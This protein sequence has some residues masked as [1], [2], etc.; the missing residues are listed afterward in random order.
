[1]RHSKHCLLAGLVCA[2]VSCALPAQADNWINQSFD[3]G[4]WR[5][6]FQ[7][8]GGAYSGET[9]RGGDYYV[10]ASIEYEWPVFARCT[11]GLRFYPLFL[12]H[13]EED[14]DYG[15]GTIYGGAFGIAGR[16]YRN[17]E[18]RRGW[19][20]E[21]G[22]ALLLHSDKFEGNGGNLNFLNEIGV[23]YKWRNDW[24]LSVKWEHI[25]NGGTSRPNSGVNT[26]ALAVGKSFRLGRKPDAL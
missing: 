20:A 15:A 25:S 1:M 10:A 16:M 7:A 23:G 13:E 21:A 2:A 18:E 5:A 6:E 4:W 8:A 12:F 24:H 11:L 9:S 17:P 19:F 14:E 22:V 3:D 26:F